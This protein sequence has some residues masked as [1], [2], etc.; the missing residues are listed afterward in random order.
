MDGSWISLGS[1]FPRDTQRDTSK[2]TEKEKDIPLTPRQ[3]ER[4]K[5]GKKEKEKGR[6]IA[7][8]KKCPL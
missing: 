3:D 2:Q 5:K 8:G 1:T 6:S 7:L 4:Q